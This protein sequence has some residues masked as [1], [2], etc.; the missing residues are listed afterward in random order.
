MV[1]C[2]YTIFCRFSPYAGLNILSMLCWIKW[3]WYWWNNIYSQFWNAC[4]LDISS[5]IISLFSSILSLWPASMTPYHDHSWVVVFQSQNR[6]HRENII[7]TYMVLKV[8][9]SSPLLVPCYPPHHH[10]VRH[11]WSPSSTDATCAPANSKPSCYHHLFETRAPSLYNASSQRSI[12]GCVKIYCTT[13][14]YLLMTYA[15]TSSKL[16]SLIASSN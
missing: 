13:V 8:L 3:Q 15:S 14:F 10:S 1:K 11:I 16:N 6:G 7:C 2:D 5:I 12:I 9:R 4:L